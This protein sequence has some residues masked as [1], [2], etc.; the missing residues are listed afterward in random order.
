MQ[1]PRLLTNIHLE[2][3][4]IAAGRFRTGVSLHSHTLHSREPLSFIY[5]YA[6][7]AGPLRWAVERGEGRYRRHHNDRSIDLS[8]AYWTPPLAAHDAWKLE[9]D[10]IE[11]HFGLNGMVSL[12]DHDSIDGPMTLRVLDS[13]HDL[14]VSVEWTVPYRETFFHLGVHNLPPERARE[15]MAAFAVFTA[16]PDERLLPELLNR[17]ASDPATLIVFNHP[18]WDEGEIGKE[19]HCSLAAV[20]CKRFGDIIHAVELNGLRPWRENREVMTMAEDACKPVI[21]GGDRHGLE[22]NATLNLTNASTFEEFVDEVRDGK[23][24]VLFTRHYFEPYAARILQ[25]VQDAMA[26][27]KNHG[28][29]WVRWSDRVFYV[30]DDGESR[31]VCQLWK[32]KPLAITLFETGLRALQHPGLQLAFRAFARE[33]AAS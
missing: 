7:Q 28:R 6:A 2:K 27:H 22:P 18:C 32:N 29:G 17:A 16:A 13:F 10:Q 15:M 24:E 5:R 19:R 8:R 20:F 30:C 25:N 11:K 3:N 1:T 4:G 12:T 23:S 33:E 21:S 26:D 9:M 31:P 14:P